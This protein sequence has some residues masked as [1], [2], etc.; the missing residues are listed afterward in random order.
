LK[1]LTPAGGEVRDAYDSWARF[2]VIEY[3]VNSRQF[4]FSAKRW[5]STL[6]SHICQLP[7]QGLAFSFSE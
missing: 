4:V 6:A 2:A 3:D 5:N 1:L 7:Q